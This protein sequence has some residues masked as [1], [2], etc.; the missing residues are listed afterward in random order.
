MR[1][2]RKETDMIA[3]RWRR[4]QQCLSTC[5]VAGR[6]RIHSCPRQIARQTDDIVRPTNGSR[7]FEEFRAKRSPRPETRNADRLK[8]ADAPGFNRAGVLMDRRFVPQRLAFATDIRTPPSQTEGI[9]ASQ[10][11]SDTVMAAVHARH[12]GF[13]SPRFRQ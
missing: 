6:M 11:I 1:Q 9:R 3:K 5:L 12:S 13:I 4:G 2:Q 10:G 7:R 8:P